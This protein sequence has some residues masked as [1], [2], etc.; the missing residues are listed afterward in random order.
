[1]GCALQF[2]K[3]AAV[4]DKISIFVFIFNKF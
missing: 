1:V 4:S 2:I 3:S